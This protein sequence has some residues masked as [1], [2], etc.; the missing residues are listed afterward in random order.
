MAVLPATR[1][2]SKKPHNFFNIYQNL[3]RIVLFE[4]SYQYLPLLTLSE[5][6]ILIEVIGTCPKTP[7]ARFGLRGPLGINTHY[8]SSSTSTIC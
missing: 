7:K 5:Y 8:L 6:K 3:I 2:K 4:R 1:L